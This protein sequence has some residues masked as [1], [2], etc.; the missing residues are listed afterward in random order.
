[1]A[2][3]KKPIRTAQVCEILGVSRQ[4]VWKYVQQGKL[5]QFSIGNSRPYFDEIAILH[6]LK[7]RKQTS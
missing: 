3:M 2:V 4:T 1:M 7:V 6:S 5:K